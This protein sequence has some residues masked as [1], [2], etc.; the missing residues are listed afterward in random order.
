MNKDDGE[1]RLLLIVGPQA[2]PMGGATVTMEVLLA[3]LEKHK[4]IQA[5][6]VDTRFAKTYRKRRLFQ[7]ETIW[8][9]SLI[10]HDYA[11][12]VRDSDAILVFANNGFIVTLVIPLLLFARRHGKRF[13]LK[14]IGGDFD[15]FLEGLPRPLRFI[16]LRLLGRIAGILAQTQ[17]LCTTL[18]AYGCDNSHYLPGLRPSSPNP[19]PS[20]N[21]ARSFRLLYLSQIKP[22]KGVFV[23]LDALNILA[24]EFASPVACDFYGPVYEDSEAQFFQRLQETPAARYC[25]IA[26]TG[27]ATQLIATYNALVLPTYFVSEGHP[28]V[29]VEAMQAGVPVIS[30]SHRAIPELITHGENGLLV[31]VQDS[32]SLADAIRQLAGDPALR[33][34]MGEANYRCGQSFRAEVVVPRMLA[35]IFEAQ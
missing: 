6:L 34:R 11:K 32:R 20:A 31:P 21:D 30:T 22:E 12:R 10:F 3:E 13:Y 33:A 28:G 24:D 16:L 1:T 27:S 9:A 14:P 23:L 25:G 18:R 5:V 26:E 8:R 7:L 29:L 4:D 17:Q 19:H 2:P 35:L 15:L